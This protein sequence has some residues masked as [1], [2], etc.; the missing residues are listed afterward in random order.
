MMNF[1]A[2]HSNHHDDPLTIKNSRPA[3]RI[4]IQGSVTMTSWRRTQHSE[5]EIQI[6]IF[7]HENHTQSKKCLIFNHD[8]RNCHI[9]CIPHDLDHIND[10]FARWTQYNSQLHHMTLHDQSPFIPH[11]S[12][13]HILKK[14]FTHT[15]E[16]AH[17]KRIQNN[18]SFPLNIT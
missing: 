14:Y 2:H 4:Y 17:T 5:R 12:F 8:I 7:C 10:N 13:Q 16:N 6:L 18:L 1:Q 15:Q 9:L 11:L 3:T